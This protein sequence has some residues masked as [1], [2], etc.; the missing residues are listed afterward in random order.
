M[1]M[2]NILKILRGGRTL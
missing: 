2:S 1:T